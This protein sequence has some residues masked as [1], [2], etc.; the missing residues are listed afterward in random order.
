MKVI[1]S[2]HR[3]SE[4]LLGLFVLLGCAS[5]YDYFLNDFQWGYSDNVFFMGASLLGAL[6][7]IMRIFGRSR[8]TKPT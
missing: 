5:A 3:G 4:L 7:C 8:R 1:G 2:S 6:F